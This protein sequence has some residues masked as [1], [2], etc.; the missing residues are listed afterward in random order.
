MPAFA[1]GAW[2]LALKALVAWHWD[3]GAG[4]RSINP[5]QM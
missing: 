2:T 5:K 4:S 3:V 1:A